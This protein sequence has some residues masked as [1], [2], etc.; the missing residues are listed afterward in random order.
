MKEYFENLYSNKLEYWEEMNELLKACD[1]TKL[2]QE[3]RKHLNV[4]KT[5]IEIEAGKKSS[6]GKKPR[7]QW[8]HSLI[9]SHL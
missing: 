4:S 2:N 5:R 9:L 7:K 1:Q 3:K 6:N 8:I